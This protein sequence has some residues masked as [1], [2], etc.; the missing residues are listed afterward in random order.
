MQSGVH[1]VMVRYVIVTTAALI[2]GGQLPYCKV[3]VRAL[4]CMWDVCL[5]PC[6]DK[7]M[8]AFVKNFAFQL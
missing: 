8:T 3:C 2:A 6:D 7:N 1:K 4:L 5:S